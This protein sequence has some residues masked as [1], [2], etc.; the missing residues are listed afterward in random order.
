MSLEVGEWQEEKTAWGDTRK[1][2]MVGGCKEYE[3]EIIT[4]AGR[5]T[6]SQYEEYLKRKPERE[7]KKQAEYARM[8]AEARALRSCPFKDGSGKACDKQKCAFFGDSCIL[9][10]ASAKPATRDTKGLK[11][12]I[13]KGGYSCVSS[14][15]FYNTGCTLGNLFTEREV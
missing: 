5:F 15:T 1:Y 10:K 14:C 3:K 4:S 2:R 7:A 11:C 9:S 13:N 12:P 8:R 6:E